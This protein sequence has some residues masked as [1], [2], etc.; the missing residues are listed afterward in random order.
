ML[1]PVIVRDVATF[2]ARLKMHNIAAKNYRSGFREPHKQRLVA[3]SVSRGGEK[4]EA[5]VAKNIVVAV[6]QNYTT[7]IQFS[8]DGLWHLAN[9]VLAVGFWPLIVVTSYDFHLP[10]ALLQKG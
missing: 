9:F 10:H 1:V 4:H 5:S 2:E 3:G 6:D 7:G 8:A